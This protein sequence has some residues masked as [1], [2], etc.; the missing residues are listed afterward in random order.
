MDLPQA[1]EQWPK[2]RKA[3]KARGVE[4][5]AIS[6]ATQENVKTLMQRIFQQIDLLPP[7]VKVPVAEMPLYEMPADEVPF[8]IT[9]ENEG[10]SRVTGN[11][12]ERAA[13]M[14]HWD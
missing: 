1:Q 7:E 4:A 2:V 10:V 11:R 13:V 8:S 6:A 3:L 5:M 12:I 14:T 9:K